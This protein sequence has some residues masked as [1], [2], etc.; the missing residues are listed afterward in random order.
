MKRRI[1]V[2]T[3]DSDISVEDSILLFFLRG[4]MMLL[5]SF[6]FA[7][8]QKELCESKVD[9]AREVLVLC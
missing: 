4:F 1:D 9:V 7:A 6:L 8:T 3:I 5:W 2:G